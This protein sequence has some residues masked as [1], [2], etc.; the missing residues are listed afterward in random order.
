MNQTL[1]ILFA[2]LL[3]LATTVQVRASDSSSCGTLEESSFAT[4]S[5]SRLFHQSPKDDV[6]SLEVT[7]LKKK[8]DL[9]QIDRDL[10]AR[11]ATMVFYMSNKILIK[12]NKASLQQQ[13]IKISNLEDSS[14]SLKTEIYLL[15]NR[16]ESLSKI[17]SLSKD[18]ESIDEADQEVSQII[19]TTSSDD[20]FSE[21][22]ESN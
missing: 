16:I 6:Q 17:K 2:G 10:Q 14:K 12:E 8:R 1:T 3:F 21:D 19:N 5:E 20:E 4:I 9:Q 11:W 7:L 22:D 13:H 18:E 15:R